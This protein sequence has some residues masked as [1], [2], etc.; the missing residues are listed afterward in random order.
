MVRLHRPLPKGVSTMI[1]H[2][3]SWLTFAKVC[4]LLLFIAS[5]EARAADPKL[6]VILIADTNADQVGK[7]IESA[8]RLMERAFTERIPAGR[9]SLNDTCVGEGCTIDGIVN[10]CKTVN[11]NGQDTIVVY[12]CGHGETVVDRGTRLLLSQAGNDE[13]YVNQITT[14]LK[15]KRPRL[16]IMMLD[17]CR[18][19]ASGNRAQRQMLYGIPKAI[20]VPPLEQSLYFDSSPGILLVHAT[21]LGQSVPC[22]IPQGELLAPGTLFSKAFSEAI[23]YREPGISGWSQFGNVVKGKVNILFQKLPRD[24]TG[25]LVL[26]DGGRVNIPSQDVDIIQF[27]PDAQAGDPGK[28]LLTP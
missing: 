16:L 4:G 13:I 20:E 22:G 28:S 25:R 6:H 27:G 10:A 23:L 19:V 8:S 3:R 11:A 5:L 9:R 26:A 18:K 17:C 14:M 21:Q 15:E 7:D 24:E 1:P 2:V 12:Y